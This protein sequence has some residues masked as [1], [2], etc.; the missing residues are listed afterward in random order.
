MSL[1]VRNISKSFGEG[2]VLSDINLNVEDGEIL[3]ILGPSGSGKSTL[4]RIICG[5]EKPDV[6]TVILGSDDV[7]EC[8]CEE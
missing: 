1:E 8:K 6:G 5:L 3:A 4:L 2:A 7:T